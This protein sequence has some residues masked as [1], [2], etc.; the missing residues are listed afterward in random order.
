MKLRKMKNNERVFILRKESG[1]Y[2]EIKPQDL[3]RWLSDGS[4]SEEDLI[5][6]SKN[7]YQVVKKLSIQDTK[8][9]E[10]KPSNIK[11]LSNLNLKWKLKTTY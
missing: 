1:Y 10:T 5:I 8:T 6:I 3:E 7:V 11:P 4:I 9:N 2:Y